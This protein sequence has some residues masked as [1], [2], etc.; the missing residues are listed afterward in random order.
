[1]G[2]DAFDF[3]RASAGQSGFR[4]TAGK[5]NAFPCLFVFGPAHRLPV[6]DSN[7]RAVVRRAQVM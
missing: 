5:M 2:S 7:A 3:G 4:D 6:L 1:M